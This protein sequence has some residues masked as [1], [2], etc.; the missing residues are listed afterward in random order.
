[1]PRPANTKVPK[2]N[3]DLESI[4]SATSK[5]TE[6][7]RKGNDRFESRERRRRMMGKLGLYFF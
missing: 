4:V 5:K 3:R 1:M 2:E 7:H 6:R